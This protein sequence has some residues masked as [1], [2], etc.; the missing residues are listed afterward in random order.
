MNEQVRNRQILAER[1]RS[2]AEFNAFCHDCYPAVHEHFSD[3][4][5]RVAKTTLLLQSAPHSDHVVSSLRNWLNSRTSLSRQK[6]WPISIALVTVSFCGVYIA[7]LAQSRGEITMIEQPICASVPAQV[8]DPRSAMVK[9]PIA[10]L[11][12]PEKADQSEKDG[13]GIA[14]KHKHGGRASPP[15]RVKEQPAPRDIKTFHN[16]FYAPVA[17]IIQN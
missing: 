16:E 13:R 2:D 11:N 4:M 5:D 12:A 10:P 14:K 9:F 7:V 6:L 3:G 1:L 15:L 17:T 8:S